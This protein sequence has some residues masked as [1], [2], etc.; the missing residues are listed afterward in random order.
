MVLKT[1]VSILRFQWKNR[2]EK[3]T[4]LAHDISKNVLRLCKPNQT[5]GRKQF[6]IDFS[7]NIGS[8]YKPIFALK[9]W[10]QDGRFD[11][12]KSHKQIKKLLTKFGRVTQKWPKKT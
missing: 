7:S 12:H 11:Y 1:I 8:F 9:P 2:L 10:N 6:F 4:N 5:A 3:R